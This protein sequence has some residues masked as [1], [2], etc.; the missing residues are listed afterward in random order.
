MADTL[1]RNARKERQGTVVSAVQDKTIIVRIERR[2]THPL[3][4]KTMTRNKKYHVHDE[5]NDA[6]LGD[7]VRIIETR[8]ISKLKRWRLAEVV[9]R[10]K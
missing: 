7:I 6:A 3:Y 2:T 1:E 10:A 4:G 5:T 9:E 8:P